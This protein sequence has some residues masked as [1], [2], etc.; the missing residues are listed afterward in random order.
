MN[1]LETCKDGIKNQ[2][3]VGIDCGGSCPELC[4]NLLSFEY[5]TSEN[6]NVHCDHI[7]EMYKMIA[8]TFCTKSII[9]VDDPCHPNPCQNDGICQDGVKM[10][11]KYTCICEP[12]FSGYNCEIGNHFHIL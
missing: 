5:A 11:K 8:I 7:S 9:F 4:G 1:S 3:E 2:D 6:M 12:R 10:K